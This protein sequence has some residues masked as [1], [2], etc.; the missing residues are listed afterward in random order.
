MTTKPIKWHQIN[1]AAKAKHRQW[2]AEV[3]SRPYYR[4]MRYREDC[5]SRADLEQDAAIRETCAFCKWFTAA[6]DYDNEVCVECDEGDYFEA[7]EKSNV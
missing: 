7:K 4:A 2:K 3:R 5:P 6:D 1:G